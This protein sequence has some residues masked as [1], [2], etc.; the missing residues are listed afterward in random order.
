LSLRELAGTARVCTVGE[1]SN[2]PAAVLPRQQMAG[3]WFGADEDVESLTPAP[4]NSADGTAVK[5]SILMAVFNEER[6]I[7]KV[8]G[9]VLKSAGPCEFELIV[10][11]DGS[12]DATSSLLSQVS[13]HRVRVLRHEGNQGKG[14]AIMSAL[15]LATGTYIL[16]F[17]AD[18]EYDP[19]DIPRLLEPVL[20]GR[21]EVVYGVR[22]FGYNTV[23]YSYLYAVGN[24][25]LTR[26]ANVLFNAHLSD[27]HT[28]LKLV[29][30]AV[31]RTLDLSAKGFGLDT[32]ITAGLLKR[33]IRPFEVPARYYGR[34][35]AQGKKIRWGDAVTCAQILVRARFWGRSRQASEHESIAED[36][37]TL[38]PFS[39]HTEAVAG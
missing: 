23:Y 27:L 31:L 26:F 22:L 32:E 1:T 30:T 12:T 39:E 7:S 16:P 5:L 29:P 35:R 25:L 20:K 33:G 17:D 9:E 14:A 37:G 38:L 13:D 19:E 11:D 3:E 6:T 4:A 34:S 15:S 21:C 8:I 36:Q 18:L 24:R 10:V 28:C 2:P